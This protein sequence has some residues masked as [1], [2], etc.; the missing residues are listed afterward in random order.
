MAKSRFP[1]RPFQRGQ[2]PQWYRQIGER[3]HFT[4]DGR[5]VVLLV[6]ESRCPC[7][8]HFDFSAP[9]SGLGAP[10]L[11]RRCKACRATG[12][13]VRAEEI[14]HPAWAPR[15]EVAKEVRLVKQQGIRRAAALERIRDREAAIRLC[16]EL[17]PEISDA[18]IRTSFPSNA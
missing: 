11:N 12:R 13:P 4:R 1:G 7:G 15:A 3:D 9:R 18:E 17:F 10:S 5:C 2:P 16:R 6:I 14:R 8:R